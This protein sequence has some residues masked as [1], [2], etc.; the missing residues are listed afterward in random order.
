MAKT[1]ITLLH[2]ILFSTLLYAKHIDSNNPQVLFEQES[3][4]IIKEL[5]KSQKTS[6]L[7]L[8]SHHLKKYYE[9]YQY[10]PFWFDVNGTTPM[11]IELINAVENDPVLKP[12][13]QKLFQLDK[14][15]MLI[16]EIERS[17][18]PDIY[19]VIRADFMITGIYDYYMKLLASG[20][21]DWEGFELKLE[22]LHAQKE[23]IGIWDRY[24]VHKNRIKL[25][26]SALKQDDIYSAIDA[27]NYTYPMVK[28]L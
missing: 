6:R 28:E 4:D 14:T 16:S 5:L 11:A 23:I 26:Y 1:A 3:S 22:E 24:G 2:V 20:S 13:S 21:I 9:G 17:E 19:K 12:V 25:L 8:S 18:A 27:V 10:H 7:F 15:M